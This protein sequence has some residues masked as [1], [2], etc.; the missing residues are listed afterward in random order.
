MNGY[1]SIFSNTATSYI[2]VSILVANVG[3]KKAPA[4]SSGF[5]SSEKEN[6]SS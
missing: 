3:R 6:I 2:E 5:S 4:F 1:E